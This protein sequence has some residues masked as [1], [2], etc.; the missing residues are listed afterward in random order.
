M[1]ERREDAGAVDC[2]RSSNV[3]VRS[4]ADPDLSGFSRHRENC[5]RNLK[6]GRA[7][8]LEL[9]KQNGKACSFVRSAEA[10]MCFMPIVKPK[11]K[12]CSA[13]HEEGNTVWN[14]QQKASVKTLEPAVTD[15]NVIS[16]PH[17]PH[18]HNMDFGYACGRSKAYRLANAAVAFAKDRSTCRGNIERKLLSDKKE[19]NLR[20]CHIGRASAPLVLFDQGKSRQADGS[21]LFHGMVRCPP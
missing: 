20:H 12:I 10:M 14:D 2:R 4:R 16:C 15:D 13:L 7:S 9:W 17:N 19:A 18:E 11:T 8:S 5:P 3:E 6:D 21:C 1:H